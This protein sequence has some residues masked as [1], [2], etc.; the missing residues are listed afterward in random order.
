MLQRPQRAPCRILPPGVAVRLRRGSAPAAL[1]CSCSLNVA[2]LFHEG[3]P[4][5]P[6]PLS[7]C[8]LHELLLA[9]PQ[10]LQHSAWRVCYDTEHDGFSLQNFYRTMKQVRDEG[11]HGIGI[12]VVSGDLADSKLPT[13]AEENT[14]GPTNRR[15][16][17]APPNFVVLGCFTPEV[18]CL[19]HSQHAFFGTQD[20]FVFTYADVSRHAPEQGRGGRQSAVGV[21]PA[22]AALGAGQVALNRK[23]ATP[24]STSSV[25]SLA[26]SAAAPH[27]P[28]ILSVYPWTLEEGNKEFMVCTNNFF[29]IGGGPDGAAIFVDAS[30]SHGTSS[31]FCETF[32]SPP[33]GGRLRATLRHSEFTVLRMI[34]FKVK[35]RKGTF[36]C[37]ELPKSEPCDCGRLLEVDDGNCSVRVR[38]RGHTPAWHRCN[39]DH[40]ALLARVAGRG[41]GVEEE[42]N[43]TKKSEVD[44]CVHM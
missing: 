29:G 28:H 38:H 26:S 6:L 15:G 44:M 4:S 8:E 21:T 40:H 1:P 37:M 7:R 13:P 11:E 9:L 31:V 17:P 25:Q 34:W 10:R 19:E 18:P 35:D 14:P 23:M 43:A 33:L 24:P 3:P 2:A 27:L 32:A 42:I 30:L 16:V 5:P 22:R 12:F 41:E 20:T 39:E 36:T